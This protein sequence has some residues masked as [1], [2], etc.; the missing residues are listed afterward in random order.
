MKMPH[1][2]LVIN[3]PF[4]NST[5]FPEKTAYVLSLFI[6]GRI[7]SPSE[8]PSKGDLHEFPFGNHHYLTA[9]RYLYGVLTS[10]S[11]EQ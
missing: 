2:G 1:S 8:F 10:L 11:F 6:L 5:I 7:G 4:A 9:H 3:E